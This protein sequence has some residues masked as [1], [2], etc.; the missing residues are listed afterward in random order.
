M[1]VPVKIKKLTDDAIIPT[2]GSE[3]AA[4][5]DIYAAIK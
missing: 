2:K 1:K 4:G 5:Y 3:D